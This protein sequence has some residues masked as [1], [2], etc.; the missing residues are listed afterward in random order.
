MSVKGK[1]SKFEVVAG[2]T[3]TANGSVVFTIR[4]WTNGIS[5]VMKSFTLGVWLANTPISVGTDE[6][7][8]AD[9]DVFTIEATNLGVLLPSLM[10]VVTIEVG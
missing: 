2:E 8:V 9:G 3:T 5:T 4:K 10:I 1:T 7:D 6:I